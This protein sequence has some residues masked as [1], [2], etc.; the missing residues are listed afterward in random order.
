MSKE[1][2]TINILYAVCDTLIAVLAI[3]AFGLAAYFFN[4]WWIVLFTIIPLGMYSQH[5]LIIDA[6]LDA[7]KEGESNSPT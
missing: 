2:K 1:L 3:A 6:D 7:A 5:T 4:K